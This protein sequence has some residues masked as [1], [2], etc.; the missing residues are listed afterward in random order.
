VI[1]ALFEIA[2]IIKTVALTLRGCNLWSTS[3]AN[4]L[5]IIHD[6]MQEM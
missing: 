1:R 4:R 5:S 3:T 2:A 6:L